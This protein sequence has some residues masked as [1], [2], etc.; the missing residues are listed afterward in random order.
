MSSSATV[1][2]PS[3]AGTLVTSAVFTGVTELL[4][5]PAPSSMLFIKHDAGR[6]EFAINATTTFTVTPS[7]GNLT[8]VVSQ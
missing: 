3:G 4:V 1:T 5:Q 7:S 8:V 6:S 2:A